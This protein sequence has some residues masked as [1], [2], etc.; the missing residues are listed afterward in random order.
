MNKATMA[1]QVAQTRLQREIAF[2]KETEHPFPHTFIVRLPPS[3]NTLA[4]LTNK[5]SILFH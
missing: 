1:T 4:I 3:F 2:L 5:S